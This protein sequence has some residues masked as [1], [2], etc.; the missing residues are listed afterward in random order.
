MSYRQTLVLLLSIFFLSLSQ[1]KTLIVGTTPEYPPF[2]MSADKT[3]YYGFDVDLMTEICKR[4]Q[5][6]CTFQPMPF[7]G[8]L[9]GLQ[10]RQIDVAIGAIIIN[11]TILEH[12]ISSVPYLESSAQ[13]FSLKSSPIKAPMDIKNKKLGV[14]NGTLFQALAEHLFQNHIHITSFDDVTDLISALSAE[15]IDAILMN[16]AA[17]KYWS[18]NNNDLY[19][20]IGNPI[21]TGKG[22]GIISNKNQDLLM[23]K[24]N[25][26]LL[27]MQNDGSYLK[28]YSRYFQ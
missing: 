6:D 13:F 17:A 11:D 10:A 5:Q 16:A 9:P 20:L 18:A 2:S 19:K 27:H 23:E 1:A 28:I 8:L 7:D 12:F 4:I 25:E 22:Y 21:P 26:A 24:I 3:H 15:S 14:R